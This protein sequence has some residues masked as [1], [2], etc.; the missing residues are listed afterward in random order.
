MIR[1][2]IILKL[3]FDSLFF[4]DFFPMSFSINHKIPAV[5]TV[6]TLRTAADN[7]IT[8]DKFPPFF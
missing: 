8:A 6:M 1:Q 4:I 7:P 3:L 2:A 5:E